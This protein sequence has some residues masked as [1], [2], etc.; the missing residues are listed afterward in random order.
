MYRTAA[1]IPSGIA[2]CFYLYDQVSN[3]LNPAS[4]PNLDLPHQAPQANQK[5]HHLFLLL[6]QDIDITG[7]PRL[8]V[9]ILNRL[10]RSPEQLVICLGVVDSKARCKR[11]AAQLDE[12]AGWVLSGACKEEE[13]LRDM[14]VIMI[15]GRNRLVTSPCPYI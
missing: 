15:L 13:D 9:S 2:G 14:V 1:L 3:A 11:E 10:G 7:Q 5:L 12:H 4:I 8:L 6:R